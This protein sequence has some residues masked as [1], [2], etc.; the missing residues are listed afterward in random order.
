MKYLLLLFISISITS[1]NSEIN[2]QDKEELKKYVLNPEN[3][4]THSKKQ[5]DIKLNISIWPQE[6][7]FEENS[8]KRD[9]ILYFMVTI[10]S[11][12]GLG[13]DA[14]QA[15]KLGDLFT[16][17]ANDIKVGSLMQ[18]FQLLKPSLVQGMLAYTYPPNKDL[19]LTVKGMGPRVM[20]FNFSAKELAKIKQ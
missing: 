16:L 13:V 15:S 2:F 5:A 19:Q 8:P 18:N 20:N 3:G 9:S 6:L 17:Y 1:C 12:V 4:L 11:E 10:S 7:L 14:Y